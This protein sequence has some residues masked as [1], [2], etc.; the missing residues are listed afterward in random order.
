MASQQ[1]I[2]EFLRCK[3]VAVIGVSGSGKGFGYAVYKNLR[4]R[5]LTVYPVN[6]TAETID[7]E[8]CFRN[9]STLPQRVEGIV[10]VVPPEVTELVVHE[11]AIVGIKQVWMQQGAE[12]EQAITFCQE[13]GITVISGEC[14]M[15]FAEPKVFPHNAHRWMH[16]IMGK[17]PR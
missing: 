10:L 12:S 4:A 3:T 15:M 8:P 1:A 7:G 14:I 16:K 11:A 6:P 9:I 13:R 2:D 5:G 17:L